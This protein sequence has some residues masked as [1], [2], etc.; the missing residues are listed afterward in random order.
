MPTIKTFNKC[1]KHNNACCTSNPTCTCIQLE[2]GGYV[3]G[4]FL[5]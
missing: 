4:P 2:N 1:R 3:D 5:G